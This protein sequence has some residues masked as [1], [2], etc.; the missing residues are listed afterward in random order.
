MKTSKYRELTEKELNEKNIK[1]STEISEL[2]F[3]VKVGKDSDYSK[4]SKKKKELAKVKTLLNEI[5]L[6][7]WK[8]VTESKNTK[9]VKKDK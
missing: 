5:N 3:D 2:K 9:T 4:I 6:G 7:I 1:L 8:P